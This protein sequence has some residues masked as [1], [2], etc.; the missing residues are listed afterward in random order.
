MTSFWVRAILEHDESGYSLFGMNSDANKAIA[1]LMIAVEFL[2]S[3]VLETQFGYILPTKNFLASKSQTIQLVTLLQKFFIQVLQLSLNASFSSGGWAVSICNLILSLAKNHY[4][5]RTLPIY[6]VAALF[7][8]GDL[9]NLVITLHFTCF[10]QV[11]LYKAGYEKADMGFI[12]ITW[13]ILSILMINVFRGA[14]RRVLF[15]LI[16]IEKI[17]GSSTEF[18]LH[19]IIISKELD[20]LEKIPG[21]RNDK[22]DFSHLLNTAH[23]LNLKAVFN[24]KA[25][26]G[27]YFDE[28]SN[29]K[30]ALR[31]IYIGY[32]E[33]LAMKY[34]RN[35]L[36]K[37]FQA[38]ICA[39]NP[40]LYT[41]TIKIASQLRQQQ[42]S[43]N[44]LTSS[45]LL[46]EIEKSI[47]ADYENSEV[48]LDLLTYLESTINVE[49]L[50]E[51]MLKL[52][53]QKISICTNILGDICNIGTIFNNSMSIHHIK[54]KVNKKVQ[55]LVDTLPD[56]Y[57][58][59]LLLFA[60]YKILMDY[61]LHDYERF[62]KLYTQRYFKYEKQFNEMDLTQDNLYQEQN[63][64]LILS[65][66][67][68][69]SGQIV[70]CTSSIQHLTGGD[71]KGYVDSQISSL[72]TPSVRS[73][74]DEFFQKIFETGSRDLMN[75]I[76]RAFFY[77]KDKNIVEAEFFLRIHPYI[78]QSLCL[79]MLVRPTTIKNQ[80]LMVREDGSL[81]A[82]TE[83]LSK[84]LALNDKTSTTLQNTAGNNKNIKAISEELYKANLAFNMVQKMKLQESQTPN[85]SKNHEMLL[86][87]Y[88]K[89]N[90]LTEYKEALEI[91]E[92]YTSKGK[93]IELT[94]TTK[95][96]TLTT[97]YYYCT[98]SIL[99]CNSNNS[100]KLIQLNELYEKEEAFVKRSDARK[101]TATKY[102][103]PLGETQRP[104][105]FLMDPTIDQLKSEDDNRSENIDCI[106]R[107]TEDHLYTLASPK[108]LLQ[109]TERGGVLISP[110][111]QE[112]MSSRAELL[113]E[114]KFTFTKKDTIGS[115]GDP[116]VI[117]TNAA[118]NLQNNQAE[119][120]NQKKVA[121]Y[122]SSNNSSIRSV[123]RSLYKSFKAA[124]K[125]KSYPKSFNILCLVF[126]AV[127]I[128][129]FI[130]QIILKVQSDSTMQ[131]LV[132]KKNLLK[133]AQ[134]FSYK[135][136]Q[137]QINGQAGA[138]SIMGA[139]L[140]NG[141]VTGMPDILA[142]LQE[143]ASAMKA[144]R[145]EMTQELASLG[146]NDEEILSHEDIKIQGSYYYSTDTTT[147][148]L[149][150]FQSAETF[151]NAVQVILKLPNAVS[152]KGYE[153]FNFLGLNI[154]DGFLTKCSEV[155]SYFVN[156]V[157]SQKLDFQKVTNLCLLVTPFA[158]LGI[159]L[160]LIGIILNQYRIGTKHLQAF[161][162][163]RPGGV[164]DIHNRL[165]R[166]KKSLKSGELVSSQSYM[167]YFGDLGSHYFEEERDESFIRKNK[168]Q[169]IIYR[170]FRRR[171]Y[172]Y[173]VRT[174]LYIAVLILIIL[175]NYFSTKHST[176]V[177]YNKQSQLEFANY[178]SERI[179]VGYSAFCALY[180]KNNT[181][182]VEGDSALS[183]LTDSAPE[184]IKIQNEIPSAFLNIDGTYDEDIK[185]ILY[186]KF[187]CDGLAT[188]ALY[189]CN[190]LIG[191]GLPVN[192]LASIASYSTILSNKVT[193]Y[194]TANKASI[195][196][197]LVAAYKNIETL[198]PQYVTISA[199]AQL[200][201][202][203][204][205][206]SLTSYIDSANQ[207]R[208]VILVVFSVIL[209][210][211][212]IMIWFDILTKLREID[213]DFK[214]VLQVFPSRLVLSSFLLKKFL[215]ETSEEPLIM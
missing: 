215:K 22:Y 173:M 152:Q 123:E 96:D 191:K 118:T 63:I 40:D 146:G 21:E 212:S 172:S 50:K 4:Y 137:M 153:A 177:I 113:A 199:E 194:I 130:S 54:N 180:I 76:F 61:S 3:L 79:Q 132:I 43:I 160:V 75:K 209:L 95:Q 55:T 62:Y 195:T 170:D 166:F 77:T 142:N 202:D 48:N 129:T 67:K 72:F 14:L 149:T 7:F 183:K 25:E 68:V 115:R 124:I 165:T 203:L 184:V 46:Y 156:S 12:I 122:L 206:V 210:I 97:N 59:P 133:N 145:T 45:F 110:R 36:V 193:D 39:K 179:S 23:T 69:S 163:L 126:Y 111:S 140:V 197:I 65:G 207:M 5:Y 26:T 20:K 106:E 89:T 13:I 64:F 131:D 135:A 168:N 141:A 205:D 49:N 175:W 213:N 34:P 136:Q 158:L 100:L 91:Y 90:H 24:L 200:M 143:R 162:K 196:T 125:T 11:L 1:G 66:K 103:N 56:N 147:R 29:R 8:Q 161:V 2:F 82:A 104:L 42:W 30:E 33:D 157:Q 9:L 32:L 155:T 150:L 47:M 134:V 169:V 154:L 99:P 85:Q 93:K 119:Q 201:A 88:I 27:L 10:V 208:S 198:Q 80:Y 78:T 83:A 51:Q 38:Q 188:W 17:S 176:K 164:R 19:K 117:D 181:I 186:G 192:M 171:H 81:E 53:E 57:V 214:R 187:T 189:N 167:D 116:S 112:I 6:K 105:S 84:A 70:Y 60:E 144:A 102:L 138:L 52:T 44:Y 148:L 190:F 101:D 174:V 16:T 28:R 86:K 120:R 204:I 178:I 109:S 35:S 121:V 92:Q 107:E 185:K 151:E 18:L 211:V 71:R 94:V 108:R 37:L 73:Y 87:S 139:L 128:V 114:K 74:Y 127:I 41:K 182:L 31:K 159:I 98:I 58:S 15:K